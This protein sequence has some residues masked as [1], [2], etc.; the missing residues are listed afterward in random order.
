MGYFLPM[1]DFERA[2][3]EKRIERVFNSTLI[4]AFL[5]NAMLFTQ[6]NR[7]KYIPEPV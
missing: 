7:V 5:D 2:L 4:A 1:A 6:H 3:L